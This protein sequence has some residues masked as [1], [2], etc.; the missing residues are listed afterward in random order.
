[1]SAWSRKRVLS[2][3]PNLTRRL[4]GAGYAYQCSGDTGGR[5]LQ[6]RCV[7]PQSGIQ[8]SYTVHALYYISRFWKAEAKIARYQPRLDVRL[9]PNAEVRETQRPRSPAGDT[10]NADARHG[11]L[12]PP[13]T[14]IWR[15]V[16]E[17]VWRR[18]RFR[19]QHHPAS[20][21]SAA[22]AAGRELRGRLVIQISL[23]TRAPLRFDVRP[24][25]GRPNRLR[26]PRNTYKTA[27]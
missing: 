22:R 18:C 9:G 15:H 16:C 26:P 24:G 7:G 13:N 27:D 8:S 1:M 12:A 20:R 5:R 14:R 2:L 3:R 4:T 6:R 21:K 10:A 19:R 17:G 23:V 25:V 11:R